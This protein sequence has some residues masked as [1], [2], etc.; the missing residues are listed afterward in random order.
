MGIEWGPDKPRRFMPDKYWALDWLLLTTRPANIAESVPVG[1]HRDGFPINLWLGVTAEDQQRADERIPLLLQV[2]A[3]VRWVSYE[4]GLGP[5][6]L[7]QPTCQYCGRFGQVGDETIG[8][9]DDGA[10]PWCIECDSEM[11]FSVWLG[12]D[13]GID[14]VVIG[15][16]SG[17]R[18]R[19]F[20]LRWAESVTAQ[21]KEAGVPCFTKQLGKGLIK[22]AELAEQGWPVQYPEPR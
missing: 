12:S 7:D 17:P 6:D 4:P 5:V 8:L 19:P 15:C 11:G 21:C 3:A 16:E 2:P 1:W 22:S 20:E 10:T 18:A 13:P 9:A 14:W